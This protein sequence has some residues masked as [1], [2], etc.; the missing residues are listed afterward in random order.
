MFDTKGPLSVNTPRVSNWASANCFL[1]NN[2]TYSLPSFLLKYGRVFENIKIWWGILSLSPYTSLRVSVSN[3]FCDIL[4][5]GVLIVGFVIV[6][7]FAV[8]GCTACSASNRFFYFCKYSIVFYCFCS[9]YRILFLTTVFLRDLISFW[10]KCNSNRG[11]ILIVPSSLIPFKWYLLSICEETQI[12]LLFL[13]NY[14]CIS[15]SLFQ[16]LSHHYTH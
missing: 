1:S 3:C 9:Y 6:E 5:I 16:S 12:C 13:C 4:V 10:G 15:L 7:S 8:F 14:F 11:Q 2:L